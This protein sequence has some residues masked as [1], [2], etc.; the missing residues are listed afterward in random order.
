MEEREEEYQR[1]RERIFAHD[2][3]A[4]G[5]GGLG[6]GVGGRACFSN[7][8]RVYSCANSVDFLLPITNADFMNLHGEA[9]IWL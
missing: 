6:A 4:A 5:V 7:L 8:C 2:V 1:A 3:R 9:L